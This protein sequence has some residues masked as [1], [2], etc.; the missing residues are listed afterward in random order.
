MP[1]DLFG[2]PSG[3]GMTAMPLTWG[4]PALANEGGSSSLI[5][6]SDSASHAANAVNG[7]PESLW[8]Q[9]TK[10]YPVY[11]TDDL[12]KDF[13]NPANYGPAA[14]AAFPGLGT[15]GTTAAGAGAA[16][17]AANPNAPWYIKFRP[18]LIAVTLFIL[19]FLLLS[20]G[21]DAVTGAKG[22]IVNIAKGVA[23][24]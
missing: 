24:A 7:Q 5:S 10:W 14:N 9:L 13:S 22:T 2:Y 6:G 1:A 18:F 15:V 21:F 23:K 12:K 16:M 20:K 17:Q 8:D 11:T 19:G 4:D 3:M